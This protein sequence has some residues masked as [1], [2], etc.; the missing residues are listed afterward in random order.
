MWK[1]GALEV[2]E[3]QCEKLPAVLGF[4]TGSRGPCGW[5]LEAAMVK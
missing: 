4:G 5:S 1:R 3:P 2:R